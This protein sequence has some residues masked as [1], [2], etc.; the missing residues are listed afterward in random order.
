M[1][2]PQSSS[3]VR[4]IPQPPKYLVNVRT[5]LNT[6]LMRDS[7]C[8]GAT[9]LVQGGDLHCFFAYKD[10]PGGRRVPRTALRLA[11]CSASHQPPAHAANWPLAAALAS[12]L[13]RTRLCRLPVV[14]C[15]ALALAL[16]DATLLSLVSYA[17]TYTVHCCVHPQRT[18]SPPQPDVRVAPR[19]MCVADVVEYFFRRATRRGTSSAIFFR[20]ASAPCGCEPTHGSSSPSSDV[21][22][23]GAKRQFIPCPVC[24][25]ACSLQVAS[26]S[27]LATCPYAH[28]HCNMR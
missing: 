21:S 24:S 15:N 5:T 9:L 17:D 7:A 11:V 16:D 23:S 25:F 22:C 26:A 18:S 1:Q 6:K 12:V 8:G 10:W 2:P 13:L 20:R 28:H 3:V 14:C 27:A 4:N 19:R